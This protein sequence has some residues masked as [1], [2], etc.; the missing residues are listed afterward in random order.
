MIF[1]SRLASAEKVSTSEEHCCSLCF[2]FCIVSVCNNG[3]Q[4][5]HLTACPHWELYL[6]NHVCRTFYM[7]IFIPKGKCFFQLSLC[8]LETKIILSELLMWKSSYMPPNVFCFVLFFYF[9]N[10]LTCFFHGGFIAL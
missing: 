8:C 6:N 5:T 9:F 2:Y 4:M 10:C 7:D 1:Y 3:P